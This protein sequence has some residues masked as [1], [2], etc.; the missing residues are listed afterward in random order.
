MQSLKLL[1]S[2]CAVTILLSYVVQFGDEEYKTYNSINMLTAGHLSLMSVPA[3]APPVTGFAFPLLLSFMIDLFDELVSIYSP[4]LEKSSVWSMGYD[5]SS[6]ML[7]LYIGGFLTLGKV[8]S[9][10]IL[11]V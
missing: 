11:E 9:R 5:C 2:A 1:L 3:S 8:Y 7:R 4:S 10:T 6:G